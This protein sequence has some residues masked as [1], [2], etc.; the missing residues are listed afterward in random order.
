MASSR[1]DQDIHYWLHVPARCQVRTDSNILGQGVMLG[2]VPFQKLQIGGV[3]L[4]PNPPVGGVILIP[5]P[6]IGGVI[7]IL[8]PLIGGVILIPTRPIRRNSPEVHDKDC[9]DSTAWITFSLQSL[10]ALRR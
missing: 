7:L 10:V 3:I 2:S 1:L 9:T 4:I 5:N 6:S 8:N